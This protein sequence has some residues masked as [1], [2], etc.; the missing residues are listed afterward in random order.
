MTDTPM[1]D[2]PIDLIKETDEGDQELLDRSRTG[3]DELSREKGSVLRAHV[4]DHG[5]VVR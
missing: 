3:P 1:S 2:D 4:D 5:L